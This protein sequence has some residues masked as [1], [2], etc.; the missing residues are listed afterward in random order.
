MDDDIRK[1]DPIVK[2]R[3]FDDE[4]IDNNINNSKSEEDI[5]LENLELEE[6]EKSI[7][8][9][10]MIES[11]KS[12]LQELIEK[13]NSLKIIFVNTDNIIKYNK[14]LEYIDSFINSSELMIMID[15]E[16]MDFINF[17]CTKTS[18][19]R[20]KNKDMLKSIF[21]TI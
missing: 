12:N 7:M 15:S 21:Y 6:I 11:K 9:Q 5:F 8:K 4:I 18:F 17:L 20:F 10:I 1:P 3:L 14:L 2:M 19:S 13:L 16:T